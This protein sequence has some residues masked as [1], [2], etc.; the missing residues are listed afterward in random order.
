MNLKILVIQPQDV[1]HWNYDEAFIRA[2][3]NFGDVTFVAK[4]DYITEINEI[5][6]INLL[7]KYYDGGAKFNSRVDSIKII[8][9]CKRIQRKLKPDITI[10]LSYD[11]ISMLLWRSKAIICEH[12]NIS[13]TRTNIIK[14]YA[15]SLLSKK[16][17]S[18][19]LQNHI[20]RFIVE[21]CKRDSFVVH[22]PVKNIKLNTHD[23]LQIKSDKITLFFP[24][25][26]N[27]E[28]GTIEVKDY[29]LKNKQYYGYIKGNTEE[30]TCCYKVSKFF[31]N[32][33]ELM[34]ACNYVIINDKYNYKVS[35]VAYEVLSLGRPIILT[36]SLFAE[37]LKSQY[38]SLV[39]I[40]NNIKEIEL[41]K[42]NKKM[43][44]SD[45]KAFKEN[46]SDTSVVNSIRKIINHVAR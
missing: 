38:P 28:C 5:S 17:V 24:S 3:S 23:L 18:V 22:H 35:G 16:L 46:I 31:Q 2:L 9:S 39:H 34:K 1:W 15:Y 26:G 6:R 14:R 12:N 37:E 32:Y 7:D 33:H 11:T 21:S 4:S 27:T 42:I 19:S 40:I 44:E 36:N 25:A 30:E 41:I 45:F 20:S 10:F 43:I 8:Q 29:L 13:N